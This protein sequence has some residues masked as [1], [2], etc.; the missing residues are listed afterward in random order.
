VA[1]LEDVLGLHRL[2]GGWEKPGLGQV[3]GMVEKKGRES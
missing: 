3:W 2:A 1:A